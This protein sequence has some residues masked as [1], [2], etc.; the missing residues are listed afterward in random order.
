MVIGASGGIGSALT[1]A[2]QAHGTEVVGTSRTALQGHIALDLTDEGSIAAAARVVGP[3]D[4]VVVASGILAPPGSS[5]ERSLRDLDAA[6]LNTVMAVNAVGPALILRHFV[7]LLPKDRRAAVAMLGARVGSIG[8]NRLGGWYGYRASKAALAMIVRSAAIEL[9][10]SHP[11][12]F[13]CAL[14]PGTVAT[15]L[16]EPFLSPRRT[17]E[18]FTPEQAAQHLLAVLAGLTPHD[19]GGHFAWDGSLI[20]P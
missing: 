20:M 12:A 10:R 2:L 5:P 15:A 1:R 3:V 14:H 7:P 4:L 13:V 17:R 19:S 9:A 8:D 16:S 6:T 11:R 18:V